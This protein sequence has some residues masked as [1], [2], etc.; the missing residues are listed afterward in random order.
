[1]KSGAQVSSMLYS[2]S[3]NNRKCQNVLILQYRLHIYDCPWEG[4]MCK[5]L[6]KSNSDATVL[7]ILINYYINYTNL[8][9]R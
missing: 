2:C 9:I 4:V 8:F 3:I 7:Y 6:T 5:C 1:M